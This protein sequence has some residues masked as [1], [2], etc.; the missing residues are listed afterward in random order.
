MAKILFKN[1]SYLTPGT[2]AK[3][4][5]LWDYLQEVEEVVIVIAEALTKHQAADHIGHSA[6]QEIAGIKRFGWREK[7]RKCSVNLQ[8]DC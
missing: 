3:F 8:C 4:Q 1:S 5:G 2:A 7:R 6:A